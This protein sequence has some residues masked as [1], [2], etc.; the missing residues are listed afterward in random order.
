M[1]SATLNFYQVCLLD[2][3]CMFIHIVMDILYFKDFGDTK[4]SPT[5]AVWVGV[6]LVIDDFC[7]V[8]SDTSPRCVKFESNR[9]ISYG[10]IAF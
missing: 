9:T 7:Y 4:V 8:S 3:S 5:N 6:N 10:D 2:G 1:N